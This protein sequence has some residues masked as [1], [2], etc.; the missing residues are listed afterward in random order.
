MKKILKA[1]LPAAAILA[2]LSVAAYFIV[3]SS[4]FVKGQ[5]LPRVSTVLG[6]PVTVETVSFSPLSRLEMTGLRVG[7]GDAPLAEVKTLRVRYSALAAVFGGMVSVS[8][9]FV[10]GA[11]IRVVQKPDGS[12]SLPQPPKSAAAEKPKPAAVPAKQKALKLDIRNVRIADAEFTFDQKTPLPATI[13]LRSV[14]LAVPVVHQGETLDLGFTMLASV[15]RNNETLAERMPVTALLTFV[16]PAEIGQLPRDLRLQLRAGDAVAPAAAEAKPKPLADAQARLFAGMPGLDKTFAEFAK[17]PPSGGAVTATVAFATTDAGSQCSV[18][19]S[20]T[21]AKNA[22]QPEFHLQVSGHSGAGTQ[23][24][25]MALTIRAEIAPAAGTLRALSGLP[26]TPFTGAYAGDVTVAAGNKISATGDFKLDGLGLA[27]GKGAKLPPLSI[28]VRHA[29]TV[30]PAAGSATVAKLEGSV[31]QNGREIASMTL[32]E[33]AVIA[34]SGGKSPA[35]SPARLRIATHD[36]DLATVAPFLPP[37]LPVTP[38]GGTINSALD[39]TV[40]NRG[41]SITFNGQA[42]GTGIRLRHG[43]REIPAYSFRNQANGSLV[44]FSRLTLEMHPSVAVENVTALQLN[45]TLTA[46]L[47]TRDTDLTAEIP[48]ASERLLAFLPKDMTRQVTALKLQG[49]LK[50]AARNQFRSITASGELSVPQIEVRLADGTPLPA[51]QAAAAFAASAD[52]TK[53]TGRLEKLELSVKQSGRP[54]VTAELS[55]PMALSWAGAATPEDAELR[56]TVDALDLTVVK[57]FLPPA[58]PHPESGTLSARITGKMAEKGT[59]FQATGNWSVQELRLASDQTAATA[60]GTLDALFLPAPGELRIKSCTFKAEQGNTP[61][62]DAALTGVAFLPPFAD[63]PMLLSVTGGTLNL[64]AMKALLEKPGAK[65]AADET[66]PVDTAPAVE[67]GPQDMKGLRATVTIDL[68]NIVYGEIAACD[69]L[70]TLEVKA[71][72]VTVKPSTL[73]LNGAPVSFQGRADL[74]ASPWKYDGVS[75]KLDKLALAPFIGTFAPK[76]KDQMAGEVK[77][78]ALSASG[79][80]VTP[81]SLARTCTASCDLSMTGVKLDNLP[82][83]VEAADSADIPELKTVQFDTVHVKF[84]GTGLMTIEEIKASGPSLSI[85]VTGAFRADKWLEKINIIPAVAG[86]L[87]ARIRTSSTLNVLL[88]A[89]NGGY[90]GFLIPVVLPTGY[91]NQISASKIVKTLLKE[92]GKR[93]ATNIA[94]GA[95]ESLGKG[96]K[97]S[98]K[99]LLQGLLGGGST[100]DTQPPANQGGTTTPAQ[101]LQ[102]QTPA[103]PLDPQQP[104]PPK[105][106]KKKAL[107]ILGDVLNNQLDPKK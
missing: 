90:A 93:A 68:K 36:F 31:V 34:W 46:D 30:D 97:I 69:I 27:D 106:K 73:T 9:L 43:A 67:P 96:E 53:S 65:A 58:A 66:A 11:K 5:L 89:R 44:N 24:F 94:T 19:L 22:A 32:S 12:W 26:L 39:V 85:D 2:V 48:L 18:E 54:V 81:A 7:G 95:L 64:T 99:K 13:R 72:T 41:S 52:L 70:A 6:M 75:M 42:S 82:V 77:S 51:A 3:G 20:G 107:D 60:K 37:K 104:V 76:L 55:A 92:A 71:N 98:G 61:L 62:A 4:W 8:E 57:P 38:L 59:A 83:L 88:C 102:P 74:G 50:A 103:T 40:E 21:F 14:N 1:S 84:A 79:S 29:V 15:M 33:P 23:T 16:P 80:G 100:T 10:D 105:K 87:E 63:R 78:L 17:L 56:L 28:A 101:Q 49:N 91:A 47:A 86:D 45:L 35:A 25:P